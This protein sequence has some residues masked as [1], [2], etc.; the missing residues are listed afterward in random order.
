MEGIRK[1]ELFILGYLLPLNISSISFWCIK[2]IPSLSATLTN[3]GRIISTY[4]CIN[5]R[6]IWVHSSKKKYKLRSK[7]LK[8]LFWCTSRCNFLGGTNERRSHDSLEQTTWGGKNDESF[9]RTPKKKIAA[10]SM[11]KIGK[12]IVD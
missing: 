10:W 5:G 3:S 12:G 7:S 6:F 2:N 8:Y 11:A 4:R 9:E 1:C